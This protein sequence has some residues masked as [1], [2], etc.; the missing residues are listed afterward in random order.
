MLAA[1]IASV[2]MLRGQ[3]HPDQVPPLTVALLDGQHLDLGSADGRVRL[4]EFWSTSCA[5]CI[6]GMPRLAETHR[7]F[8][9]RG[10]EVV[11]VAMPYDAPEHVGAFARRE[12]L[13]FRVGFDPSGAIGQ[14]FGGVNATPT[15]YL[16]DRDGRIVKRYIGIPDH[17][18][19]DQRIEQ[20]L[21][22][23]S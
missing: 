11:A 15:S 18:A 23:S 8:A 16:I 2:L 20:M 5:P 6:R 1:L 4:V 14:G 19:L 17:R 12:N 7:K 13:P 22:Q 3:G 21:T 9:A 10:F